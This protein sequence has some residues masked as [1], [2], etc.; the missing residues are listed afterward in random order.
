MTGY[1]AKFH[2]TYWMV[3]LGLGFNTTRMTEPEKLVGWVM[4]L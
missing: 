1:E 4:H 3:K 2:S